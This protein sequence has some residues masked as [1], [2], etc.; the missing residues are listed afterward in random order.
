MDR[1]RDT[2]SRTPA[3]SDRAPAA[4]NA[5]YDRA[6]AS[7]MTGWPAVQAAS[8]GSGAAGSSASER[9]CSPAGAAPGR[10]GG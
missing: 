10:A 2:R 8:A 9:P 4:S 6:I 3:G 7:G 1:R 5:A